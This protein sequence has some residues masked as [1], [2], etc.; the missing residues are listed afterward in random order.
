MKKPLGAL[1]AQVLTPVALATLTLV[2]SACG[3]GGDGS[4]PADAPTTGAA[5][6]EAELRY[7]SYG[8][9]HVKAANFKG[10]GYGY[11]YAFATDHVCLFAQE[12]VTMRGERSKFFG[13]ADA[14]GVP[15]TYLGQSGTVTPNLASDFFYKLYMTPAQAAAMKAAAGQETR[16]LVSGFVAGYN[17]YLRD[18]GANGLPNDCKGAPWV[19]PMTEEELYWR[20]SQAA[21][22]GSSM[23]FINA[24]G[25]AQP[26]VVKTAALLPGAKA[27]QKKSTQL[28]LLNSPLIRATDVLFEHAIGSNGYGLGKGVTQS[29]TGIVMGNPHFPWWGALRLHQLH[30]TIPG[31]F[32]VMGATLLGAPV[33]LI[34][35][36]KDVAWTHTFST[37][38]RFTLFQL[39]LDPADP[40]R[41]Q[42]D[43]AYKAMSKTALSVEVLQPDGT[44]ATQQ[45]T[46]YGTDF[47]PLL[48]DGST[49]AWSSAA[50]FAIRDANYT[51]YKLIDQVIL[52]AKATSADS[53]RQNLATHSALP[54]VNTM[55]ADKGGKALFANYSVAANVSDAQLA[56]CV[57]SPTAQFLLATRGQVLMDGS[58]SSCNWSGA[59]G[60]AE[61]P[62]VLR[63]DYVVNANDSH[64][65]PNEQVRL[66][67]HPKIIATGPNAEGM[68]Q[69]ERTR[70][71]IVQVQDR[72]SG[73]DGLAGTGFTVANLQQVYAKSRFYKAEIWLDE[74]LAANCAGKPA[75][76]KAKDKNGVDTDI[77]RACGVLAIWKKTEGLTD[78]GA[79]LFRNFYESAGELK[80]SAY[81]RVAFDPADPVRTPRG[82]NTAANAKALTALADAVQLMNKAG[83]ALEE[84]N[85]RKQ[86]IVRDSAPIPLPGGRY[87]F[88]NV[89]GE[90]SNG[91][92]GDPVYG[93]SYMQF[94]T[95][96]ANGPVAEGLLTYS[97][98]SHI[99]SPQFSDQTKLYSDIFLKG[100]KWAKLPFS[101]AEI[102][103]DPAYRSLSLRE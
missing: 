100:A 94:V 95:F 6:Y 22:T 70:M 86:V 69:G 83:I 91:L 32:D 63:D 31:Q 54:W 73:A 27:L 96:D 28:A 92:Y 79:L 66:S 93:N 71:G 59:I 51:N 103:A 30:L 44:L 101:E 13:A 53:L 5:Q 35:F 41:Y 24:V 12:L 52:N 21:M 29:G 56:S 40:T 76:I 19:R 17:R 9:P 4:N 39:K 99:L 88:N 75:P 78:P 16:D 43:G 15:V 46:L 97:Q 36:N 11:G 33:P 89:R 102:K 1:R 81:W 37:D 68:P 14:K 55:A 90:L 2:L 47:G 42:V 26:P 72:M 45:R 65:L 58:K 74:F 61:R 48:S 64:W 8:V 7:T 23:A 49:F 62:Y 57:N 34:G 98:S 87:T 10:L 38:N 60:A 67:K 25:S 50:A 20:F 85:A 3:G 18:Q 77:T 84:V 80:E 82:F